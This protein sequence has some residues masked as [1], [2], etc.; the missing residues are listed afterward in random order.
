MINIPTFV[1][2]QF[3]VSMMEESECSGYP[4]GEQS[5]ARDDV[6]SHSASSVVPSSLPA[7]GPCSVSVVDIVH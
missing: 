6:I 4:Y 5:V 7:T 2:R 1:C 3:F